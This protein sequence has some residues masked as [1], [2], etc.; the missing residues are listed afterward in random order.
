M[1]KIVLMILTIAMTWM[2]YG[3]Q[4][5]EETPTMID[6]YKITPYLTKGDKSELLA[7]KD[8]VETS[9]DAP[10]KLYTVQVNP[11]ITYQTMDGFGAAMTESSAYVINGLPLEVQQ[12]LMDDLFGND[13]IGISFV[14]I[15]M[16]A[17]DFALSNYSYNDL[18]SGQTDLSMS[19][20]SIARDEE[21][22]IP[23]IKK[24]LERNPNLLF[25]GS[26]WSAPAW[27]KTTQTMNGG[28]LN[29]DYFDAYATYFVKFIQ[30]YQAHGIP[31]YAVTPQNEPLHQ[32][33]SYPT[34]YMTAS[35]QAV[36][37]QRLGQAFNA[38]NIDT[39]IIAYDHNWT[40]PY[41]VNVV[42]NPLANPYVD[43]AAYHC[44]GG[45][46]SS[47]D[48]FHKLYPEKGIWFTECSGG[49]WATDF[50]SNMSWNLENVFIGSINYHAKGVLMWNLAL[51]DNDGPTNG[52]CMNCRGVVTI[53]EDGTYTKNEEYYMIGHFSKF[54]RQGA[55]RIDVSSTHASLLVTGFINPD[56]SLVLVAHNKSRSQISFTLDIGG[57]KAAMTLSGSTT[58]SYVIEK[59]PA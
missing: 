26:P 8:S 42:G 21:Y 30:A 22:V 56:G 17:S 54:I 4:D 52:G 51:D 34:M 9:L 40:N 27:M 23:M 25:I 46:V 20:F 49:D 59:L 13:G 15:P 50:A 16:G 33:T 28:S 37:I 2:I 43:G 3:C 38:N 41:P 58:A 14:R 19:Q 45:E 31:I 18:P 44:Y 29:P 10:E 48:T 36:F 55:T 1:K 6:Q 12:A 7:I 47:Q 53:H 5:Q 32:T 24:A 57:A 39:L 11:T 35:D